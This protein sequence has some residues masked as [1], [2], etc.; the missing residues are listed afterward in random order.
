MHVNELNEL[1]TPLSKTEKESLNEG[2]IRLLNNPDFLLYIRDCFN[3]ANPLE[4]VFTR[5]NSEN[6]HLAAINDS[7]KNHSRY[8]LKIIINNNKPKKQKE[9][10]YK[11]D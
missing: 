8:L 9:T 1:F 11:I 7:E 3:K 6:T 2:I 10:E 5:S 4:T